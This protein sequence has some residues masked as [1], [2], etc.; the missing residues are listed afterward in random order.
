MYEARGRVS[1]IEE[2]EQRNI[3]K[4]ICEEVRRCAINK[5]E[6]VIGG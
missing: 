3:E 6:E 2:A 4:L 5:I 1:N